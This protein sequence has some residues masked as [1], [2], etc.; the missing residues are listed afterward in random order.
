MSTQ[1]VRQ[2]RPPKPP[3]CDTCK[4]RRVLC[5]PQPEGKPCPRCAE[6]GIACTT[7]PVVR[8]RPRKNILEPRA[9]E[10]A[11]ETI[12]QAAQELAVSQISVQAT[13]PSV[14]LLSPELHESLPDCPDLT[15]ELVAHFFECFEYMPPIT[16]PVIAATS[17]KTVIR[18]VSFQLSLLP[19]QL[20]VLAMCIVAFSSLVSFHEVVL[21]PGVLPDSFA[22][23]VFFSAETEVSNENAASCFLLELLEQ[24]NS[25]GLSRPWASAYISHVRALAPVWRTSPP[26]SSH[27]AGFLMAEALIS[28]R[29]RKPMLITHEDQLLLCGS[30]PPSQQEFLA[31]LEA[32]LS[33]KTNTDLLFQSM[34]PYMFHITALA[35]QLWTT[36]TGD[37]LQPSPLSESA[38]LQFLSALSLNHA[39]VSHLLALAD[40][41]LAASAS[42]PIDHPLVVDRMAEG[43]SN[44]VRGCA[45][46][47]IMGFTGL[48]L[49]L[50]R[51]LEKRQNVDTGARD[52]ASS[53]AHD[54]MRLLRAQAHQITVIAVRELARAIRYLSAVH[55]VPVQRKTVCD[56]V[57]FAL[58]DAEG[59]VVVEPDRVRDLQTISDQLSLAGYSQDLFSD[60]ETALLVQ[61]LDR[62]IAM[63]P[64]PAGAELLH[65]FNLD[66][67]PMLT[68]LLLPFDQAWMNSLAAAYLEMLSTRIQSYGFSPQ[69]PGIK[70]ARLKIPPGLFPP[71][72]Y[73]P[74]CFRRSPLFPL[75]PINNSTIQT[76]PEQSALPP[77]NPIATEMQNVMVD[78]Y[79]DKARGAVTGEIESDKLP[80]GNSAQ[81]EVETWL[82]EAGIVAADVVEDANETESNDD[83]TVRVLS[84][85]SPDSLTHRSMTAC[86]TRFQ[87]VSQPG[88]KC[89][90]SP[91]SPIKLWS[92]VHHGTSSIPTV[93]LKPKNMPPLPS[94]ASPPV[95]RNCALADTPA[96]GQCS[97]PNEQPLD[98]G[99]TLLVIA[100]HRAAMLRTTN[101]D[102]ESI[103]H[104]RRNSLPQPQADAAHLQSFLRPRDQSPVPRLMIQ[105]HIAGQWQQL[106]LPIIPP[107]SKHPKIVVR[108]SSRVRMCGGTTSY[109]S[110]VSGIS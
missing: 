31:S 77:R 86:K 56:Y 30:E 9:A 65:H 26:Y 107:S 98:R 35:R 80:C 6:K 69:D 87:S 110:S 99:D 60:Q 109:S 4:A 16:N 17:I 97:F 96:T 72:A 58:D 37:H 51:E 101:H 15:P 88:P 3:A 55:F 27:W 32:S 46:G 28:T 39:I 91:L 67:D 78:S 18:D 106:R 14:N 2:K 53:Y 40:A 1:R 93:R 84:Y 11:P 54:R 90:R 42:A 8:G 85:L 76:G 22:D 82:A 63:A 33:G 81:K 94:P 23:P 71:S 13:S 38:V 103:M 25:H 83:T 62:Y 29:S 44:T 68:D 52:L 12:V 24:S 89:P 73:S 45:Y 75:P 57:R 79:Q 104:H 64:R 19:Q 47:I 95:G 108:Q 7:T 100:L 102:A 92:A 49:P 61:R 36:I 20:R 41:A 70:N 59:T 5:H 66:P 21:G 105:H 34:K 74:L 48:V 43:S 50:Y 10:S